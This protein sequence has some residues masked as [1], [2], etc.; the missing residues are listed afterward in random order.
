MKVFHTSCDPNYIFRMID[1]HEMGILKYLEKRHF[2]ERHSCGANLRPDSSPLYINDVWPVFVILAAGLATSTLCVVVEVLTAW[3]KTRLLRHFKDKLETTMI[4]MA[5]W[6]PN[7][8]IG[9]I[10]WILPVFGKKKTSSKVSNPIII[11]YLTDY[12]VNSFQWWYY[13]R[14]I[15]KTAFL[16]RSYAILPQ[17]ARLT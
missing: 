8:F 14:T 12:D 13:V 6:I 7:V 11:A 17:I 15:M 2:I 9:E 16:W 5:N 1:L 10:C 4:S 3:V